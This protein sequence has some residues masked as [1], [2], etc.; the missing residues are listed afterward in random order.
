MPDPRFFDRCGPFTLTQLADL[1]EAKIVNGEEK[2]AFY[3][4]VAP[5]D[6]ASAQDVSFFDNRKYIDHYKKSKA[7]VILVRSEYISVAPTGAIL[8]VAKD[9]YRGYAKIAQAFY[10]PD[11]P[12]SYVHPSAVIEET[13]IIGA[14]C[15]IGPGFYIG[16][17]V[18]IGNR[19]TIGPNAVVESGVVVGDDVDIG[20]NV[21]ISH[22]L[23]GCRV[24]ILPGARLGQDGF[25]FAMSAAGHERVPQ[26]GRVI[27]EDDVDIGAN[28]TVDRGAGPDT[29][30][31]SGSKLDNLIQIAHNVQIGRGCVITAQCGI[32]GSSKLGD[33]VSM[34]GQ[35]GV[36]GHLT[37]GTGTRI[38]AQSGVIG[39]IQP[40]STV[41][42]LPARPKQEWLRATALLMN[43]ARRERKE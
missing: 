23:I 10:K 32:S 24:R 29:V 8:L 12:I 21:T 11:A 13:V 41:G 18:R 37:V 16:T 7:G 17:N 39:N 36:A 35:S 9:P 4:D 31:G 40:G 20:A 14:N 26:L 6:S 33:F 19:V 1:S 27:I 30:I 43:M 34:G 25:G 2:G 28:T 22:S 3:V 5:L 38:A 15:R 42:G